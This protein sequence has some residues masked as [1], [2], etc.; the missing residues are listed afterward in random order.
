M[1]MTTQMNNRPIVVSIGE[2]LWDVFPNGRTLGGAPANFACHAKALGLDA[3]LASA[4][5]DDELGGEAIACL[6]A[7]GVNV[8]CVSIVK[9]VPTG[10][11]NVSLN[12]AG[13][14]SYEILPDVAWDRL[15]FNAS[16]E[17]LAEAADAVCF[18]SLAQR[19]ACFRECLKAF[20]E[21]MPHKALKVFDMNLRSGFIRRESVMQ[22]LKSCNVLKLNDEEL[23]YATDVLNLKETGETELLS[24]VM[25]RLDLKVIALTK[26]AA[27]CLIA[28]RDGCVSKAAARLDAVVDTVG[29]GDAF[30]ACFT[31]GLLYGMP[32]EEI[33]EHANAVAGY[34]CG[35][36]GATPE[37]PG[38]IANLS[39]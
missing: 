25:S 20:L 32:M 26:G 29:A 18:G 39:Q 8:D 6:R 33:A 38:D 23:P 3:R 36:Y 21:A 34:V 17:G 28:T 9:G 4:V 7:K 1:E 31:A 27:G 22:S 14:P 37:L 12:A 11:V 13:K 24:A 16:L 10:V 2:S 5:G 19:G 15:K 35:R 30:T